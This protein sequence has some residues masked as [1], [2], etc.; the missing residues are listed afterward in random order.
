MS[1]FPSWSELRADYLADPEVAAAYE[2][3]ARDLEHMQSEVPAHASCSICRWWNA[4]YNSAAA[5][6]CRRHAP[7][8]RGT[9]AEWPM[10]APDTV[11][12][13][14]ETDYDPVPR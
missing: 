5:G 13:D 11:C 14:W 10:T 9:G 3:L 7:M 1:H 2:E 6:E 8:M 12:G 4:Y